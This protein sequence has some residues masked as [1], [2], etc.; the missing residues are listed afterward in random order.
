MSW[1]HSLAANLIDW[2]FT[3]LLHNVQTRVDNSIRTD[4][5]LSDLNCRLS[6]LDSIR[7]KKTS[8]LMRLSGYVGSR[9]RTE[10]LQSLIKWMATWY[11]VVSKPTIFHT[12][13]LYWIAETDK[14]WAGN[15]KKKKMKAAIRAIIQ[16]SASAPPLAEPGGEG[17]E[18]GRGKGGG[19]GPD[20]NLVM[21]PR[22]WACYRHLQT[23][24]SRRK[25]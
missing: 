5:V 3:C 25:R 15:P 24:K 1:F 8:K 6:Q 22:Y 23:W 14:S 16:H 21:L 17:R 20:I 2:M 11:P 9:N 7:G 19:A 13:F 18:G 10:A 12:K 4:W